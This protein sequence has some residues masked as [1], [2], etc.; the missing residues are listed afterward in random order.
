LVTLPDEEDGE[1]KNWLA[2]A[3]GL[4]IAR[5]RRVFGVVY[6]PT[7]GIDIYGRVLLPPVDLLIMGLHVV[8]GNSGTSTELMAAVRGASAKLCLAGPGRHLV[9]VSSDTKSSALSFSI[10]GASQP[11][12][13]QA[14][15]TNPDLLPAVRLSFRDRDRPGL[16]HAAL[17]RADGIE[18]LHSVRRGERQIAECS[19]P[20]G[21]KG[22][23]QWKR[24]QDTGWHNLEL[25]AVDPTI[26]IAIGCASGNR[27][28]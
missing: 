27:Q 15:K 1:V 23:L 18:L 6:P 16:T 3:T 7:T 5:Q 10:D 4:A 9:H 13:L 21:I 24:D 25:A 14:P 8:D 22:V 19:Y 17:H 28:N 11:G 26:A 12:L 20:A 2:Q